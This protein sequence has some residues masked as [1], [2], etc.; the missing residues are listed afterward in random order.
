[1]EPRPDGKRVRRINRVR[2]QKTECC[3]VN[4]AGVQWPDLG[5]LKPSPPRCELFS[6]LRLPI[7]MVFP[8]VGEAGLELQ[9]SGYLAASASQNA[10][11]TESSSVAQARLQWC[12]LGSLQPPLPGFK[13]FCLSLTGSWDYRHKRGFAMLARLFSNSWPQMIRSP[14]PQCYDY[15]LEPPH[16]AN[17][18]SL[19][20]LTLSTRLECNGAVMAHCSFY[21]LGLCDPP[22]SVSQ[23]AGTTD[24]DHQMG[25][26]YV[27]QASLK[28]LAIVIFP[29]WPPKVP[30]LQMLE[31]SGTISAHCNLHLS[32]SNNSPASASQVAGITGMCHHARLIFVFLV[33]MGFPHV[34]QAGLQLLALEMRVLLCWAGWSRT[35]DFMNHSPRP[36][37]LLGL[38]SL[39]LSPRLECNG[40]I[41]VHCN[42]HL[43][44]SICS[45]AS[46]SQV[47]GITG[48]CHH[49]QLIILSLVEAGFHHRWD[50]TMLP[51][52]ISN[53]WAQAIL[54]PWPPK[55]TYILAEDTDN[56]QVK[57]MSKRG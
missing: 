3:S 47:A 24:V 10:V 55:A 31:Y 4:Q 1:M 26:H 7:E 50:N 30:E 48:M 21:L 22:T 46:V 52:L 39:T 44:G 57:H 51:R 12:N 34:N 56:K 37:K 45:P 23:V 13:Q 15:R 11:I 54:P 41:T 18:A 38:Q 53:F 40:A 43:P 5:F 29:P 2:L 8:H 25:C 14:W 17:S 28:L 42:L 33:E 19:N 27:A 20:G 9:T 32:G 49:A 36:L 6:S 16:P 35:A